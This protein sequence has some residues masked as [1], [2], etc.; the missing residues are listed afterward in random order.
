MFIVYCINAILRRI[1]FV[2]SCSNAHHNFCALS[3]N[4]HKFIGQAPGVISS[5][6]DRVNCIRFEFVEFPLCKFA[7]VLAAWRV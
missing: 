3:A 6:T 5:T 2:I 4:A 7:I 1:K